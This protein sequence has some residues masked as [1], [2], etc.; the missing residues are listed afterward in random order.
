MKDWVYLTQYSSHLV[1]SAD[2]SDLQHH[3]CLLTFGGQLGLAPPCN[4]DS[5]VKHVLDVG[6]GTG[7]WAMDFGD[8]HPESHVVGID[9]SPSQPGL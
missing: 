4:K 6:T 1:Q 2:F 8:E 3:L 5:K 7:I 9:L